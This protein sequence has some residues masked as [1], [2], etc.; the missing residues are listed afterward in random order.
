MTFYI[1][2]LTPFYTRTSEVILL[3]KV[4]AKDCDNFSESTTKTGG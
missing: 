3:D 2:F 1:E 4:T